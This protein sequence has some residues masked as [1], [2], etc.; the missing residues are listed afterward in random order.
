[1]IF[2]HDFIVHS[3]SFLRNR[4]YLMCVIITMGCEFPRYF[5]LV[6]SGTYTSRWAYS[7]HLLATIFYYLALSLVV[8]SIAGRL[9]GLD[10]S[11]KLL[12]GL[13]I[14]N[15]VFAVI[16]FVA[17][18]QC[19]TA[20]TLGEFFETPFYISFSICD[21][22]KNC[23]FGGIVLFKAVW[24]LV[25]TKKFINSLDSSASNHLRT[26]GDVA[27]TSWKE[28]QSRLRTERRLNKVIK[29]LIALN[30]CLFLRVI[31]LSIKLYLLVAEN[32]KRNLGSL[33][34]YGQTWSL[35]DDLIPR[36]VPLILFILAQL[37]F[38]RRSSADASDSTASFSFSASMF[39][40]LISTSFKKSTSN[41]Q[42]SNDEE[43]MNGIAI[44]PITR[45][46]A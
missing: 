34:L 40:P 35:L 3:L 38:R 22:A 17:I 26:P 1:M 4:R 39:A 13:M 15:A 9:L 18:E 16:V 10:K 45:P 29:L 24:N 2:P 23:L 21:A 14:S 19:L 46:H 37:K 8:F 25:N 30:L 44:S 28:E 41:N 27:S 12:K 11:D 6:I 5:E 36:G 43:A 20:D 33:L 7:F 32:G 42:D 31:T